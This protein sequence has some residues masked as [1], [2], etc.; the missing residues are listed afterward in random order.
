M[1]SPFEIHTV[2]DALAFVIWGFGVLA[3]TKYIFGSFFA[4]E[5]RKWAFSMSPEK[6]QRLRRLQWELRENA[7]W[8][9]D[10]VRGSP[11]SARRTLALAERAR[12]QAEFERMTRQSLW[13]RAAD[14]GVN[15][16]TCQS[17]WVALV[18]FMACHDEAISVVNAVAGACCYGGLAI[19]LNKLLDHGAHVEGNPFDTCGIGVGPGP[20][21][22][23]VDLVLPELVPQ[24]SFCR[25]QGLC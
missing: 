24:C 23:G 20:E 11:H 19:T 10:V 2:A 7:H 18:L 15:C 4:A 13:R 9:E 17:F 3:L 8:D 6:Q 16:L 5:F 12:R 1:V 22:L 14:F 25:A 21:D